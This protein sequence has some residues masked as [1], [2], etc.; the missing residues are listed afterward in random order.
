MKTWTYLVLVLLLGFAPAAS[1]GAPASQTTQCGDSSLNAIFAAAPG[2]ALFVPQSADK[3]ICEV[4]CATSPCQ[5]NDECT[6]AP[7]GR[8]DLVCPQSGCCVYPQ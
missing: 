4:L 3:P 5:S 6:A 1:A 2:N 7:H 8:C